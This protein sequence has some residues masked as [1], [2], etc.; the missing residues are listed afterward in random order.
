MLPLAG[1]LHGIHGGVVQ[2]RIQLA[3]HGIDGIPQQLK[4]L[5]P[6]NPLGAAA[7]ARGEAHDVRMIRRLK[8][9]LKEL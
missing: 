1:F 3:T 2:H 5:Q 7:D 4:R 9:H 6:L 8:C